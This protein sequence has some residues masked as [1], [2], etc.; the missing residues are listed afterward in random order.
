MTGQENDGFGNAT[1][2][3]M[4]LQVKPACSWHMH[5]QDQAARAI[6]YIDGVEHFTGRGE[7]DGLKTSREDQLRQSFPHSCI[8]VD[9]NDNGFGCIFLVLWCQGS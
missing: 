1:L 7:T 5:V 4:V 6:Q 3:Q 9:D 8:V 2:G